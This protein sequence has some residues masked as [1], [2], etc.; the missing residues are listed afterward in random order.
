VPALDRY[1]ALHSINVKYFFGIPRQKTEARVA[2]GQH[3]RVRLSRYLPMRLTSGAGNIDD[4]IS[5]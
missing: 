5:N 4:T 3:D 1:C 2:L